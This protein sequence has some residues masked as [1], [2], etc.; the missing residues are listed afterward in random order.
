MGSEA[1]SDDP[2]EK[3]IATFR[4]MAADAASA[5][6]MRDLAAS[7]SGREQAPV[8]T[9]ATPSRS[10]PSEDLKHFQQRLRD[11]ALADFTTRRRT[12]L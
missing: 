5:R 9:Q 12:G 3:A 8:Q 2:F 10:D 4:Q 7:V 6:V 11:G 1:M